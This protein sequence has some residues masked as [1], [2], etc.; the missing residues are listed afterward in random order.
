MGILG[1]IFAG[2]FKSS[3]SA[4]DRVSI[5]DQFATFTEYAPAFS[6]WQGSLYEHDLCRTAVERFAVACSK[7]KPEIL[8]SPDTKPKVRKLF[9]SWPNEWQTWP[10]FLARTAT[11]LETDTTAYVVPVL[12]ARNDV[13]GIM[14][15]KPAYTEVAEVNGVAWAVF[16]LVTGEELAMEWDRIAVLTRFQYMSDFFGGGNGPLDPT[17][18][19]MDAQ[20]QAEE[21]AVKNGSRIRFIGRVVGMTHE[22]Q[23]KKKRERFYEDNIK[24]NTSGLLIYDNTFDSIQQVSEAR[25]VIDTSEMERIN[26]SVYSYFGTNQDILQNHYSEETFGAWYEGKVE[27]FALQLSEGLTK[28]LFTSIERKHGCEVMF[29]SSKLA[30]ASNA[31]KR[32]M[33]RDMVDRGVMSL[34]EAR[35]VLQLPPVEGGDV[36][37]ARGEY[38]GAPG[39]TSAVVNENDFDLGGDDD[40]YN[41][42]DA[43]GEEDKFDD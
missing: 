1:D 34:N 21:L 29:S 35:E 19:L 10:Q 41:D 32:N 6:S 5:G 18:S 30:Y 13:A 20:R 26:N 28:A 31:S 16:H 43:R 33:V 12:D 7:L 38:K 37:L 39:I 14:P 2:A 17:L 27:P 36:F 25:Y 22:D 40:I 3:E 9:S 11:I 4:A 42:T 24:G 8:G 15:L 23:L